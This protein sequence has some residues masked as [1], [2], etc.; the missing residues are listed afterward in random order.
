[1]NLPL[2]TIWCGVLVR[3]WRDHIMTVRTES[4]YTLP[5]GPVKLTTQTHLASSASVSAMYNIGLSR[6]LEKVVGLR[7]DK[8]DPWPLVMVF[9]GGVLAEDDEKLL[10][11]FVSPLGPERTRVWLTLDAAKQQLPSWQREITEGAM[12]QSQIRQGLP[13][14]GSRAGGTDGEI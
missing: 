2:L 4:G 13:V 7:Q 11:F 5:G 8:N 10:G 6:K 12:Q 3:N 1:M 9:D 14:Y